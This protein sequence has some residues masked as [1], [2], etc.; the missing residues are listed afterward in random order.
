MTELQKAIEAKLLM[1]I[2]GEGDPV[3]RRLLIGEYAEFKVIDSSDETISAIKT[4]PFKR[5]GIC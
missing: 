5:A 1:G 4:N 3:K 2:L